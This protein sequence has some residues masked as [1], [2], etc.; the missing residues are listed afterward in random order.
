MIE[1]KYNE[2]YRDTFKK[3]YNSCNFNNSYMIN[4][5]F[6]IV[7]SVDYVMDSYEFTS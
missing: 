7:L 2:E 1:G 5:Y 3:D 4:M 6:Y